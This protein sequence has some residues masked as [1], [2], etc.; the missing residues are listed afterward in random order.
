MSYK[1]RVQTTFMYFMHGYSLLYIS[2]LIY[3]H[4]ILWA[5]TPSPRKLGNYEQLF[6]P[7]VVTSANQ[8]WS[9]FTS[10]NNQDPHYRIWMCIQ[11]YVSMLVTVVD[12]TQCKQYIVYTVTRKQRELV[13]TKQEAISYH[14][15]WP[16]SALPSIL[17]FILILILILQPDSDS[18]A[19]FWFSN[20]NLILIR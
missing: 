14:L 13:D 6:P 20:L 4:R 9:L 10:Y 7:P 12:Y 16:R 3:N 17:V 15:R 18:L 11:C 8:N 2:H 19:W 5:I 1:I